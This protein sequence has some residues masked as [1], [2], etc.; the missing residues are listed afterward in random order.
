MSLELFIPGR[1]LGSRSRFARLSMS[2]SGE[3]KMNNQLLNRMDSSADV[4]CINGVMSPVSYCIMSTQNVA[5]L[6]FYVYTRFVLL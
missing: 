5:A 6:Y 1:K 4:H 2:I 3:E